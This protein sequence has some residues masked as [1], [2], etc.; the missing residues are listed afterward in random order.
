[1]SHLKV[2]TL[3]ALFLKWQEGFA[4]EFIVSIVLAGYIVFTTTIFKVFNGKLIIP[5]ENNSGTLAKIK[6]SSSFV[7]SL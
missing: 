7:M 4:L 6:S 1:M 5:I 2:H 3:S